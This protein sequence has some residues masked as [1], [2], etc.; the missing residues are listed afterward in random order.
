MQSS[1]IL[2]LYSPLRSPRCVPF[3]PVDPKQSFPA[4]ERGILAYWKKED[5]FRRSIRARRGR[6]VFRFYDGPPFATGLPHY[7]H[8]LAGTIKDVIPRYQTMRGK[9]VERR[10]GWDC[11]GL[12]IEYEIEKEHGIKGK[13]DIET[14]GIAKF[15]AL[16]RSAV[17][18]YT[19]EWRTTVER[20]GRWVDM[21]WDYR[22]MDPDYMESIWW[23]FKELWEKKL[24]EE[25]HKPMHVCP[26]CV[27]P[28]SNFEVT[29]GYKEVT[30][31]GV[32]VKFLSLQ[33]E[34]VYLLAWTTTPWTLPGN[35]F[36]A[37]KPRAQYVRV[38][39]EW[40]DYIVAKKCV[41]RIFTGRDY[42]IIGKPFTSQ[43]LVGKRYEPVFP[44]F[45]GE[46]R[47]FRIVAADFVTTD[48]GTGIV[49]IA[50]GFGEDDYKVWERAFRTSTTLSVTPPLLQHVT[51]DGRFT[52]AVTDFAGWEVKPK[53]DPLKT[54]GKIVEYLEKKGRVF[55]KET[56][57][58]SYPHCWRCDTPLLNYATSSWFVNVGKIKED[59]LTANKETE[60][61]PAHLR[62]GRF[63]K[64]LDGA[65][66][67]AISRQRYWG[68][69]LPIWRCS[70]D[71]VVIGSRDDLMKYCPERF[72]KVTVL[73]HG[74]SEGNLREIYQGEVPGTS[75]TAEGKRQAAAAALAFHAEEIAAIY[76]SPLARTRET[77]AIIGQIAGVSVT[78]DERLRESAFGTYEG[79][80][81]GLDERSFLRTA[82]RNPA[83]DPKN[84]A[85]I[86]Q[87]AG[88][89]MWAQVQV[90]IASFFADILPR[91]RGAHIIL[92]SHV[93]PIQ[94]II[95]FFT[96]EDPIKISRQPYPLYAST[97]TF[98]WD[99][100]TKAEL[101]LHRETVDTITWK[102]R[103][104]R[105]FR[106]IPDV[107]DC[108]FESGA[109]PYA[110][111]EGFPA[112]FIA[113]GIDQTRGWF[114]TLMVLSTALF[115]RPA[116]RHCIVNGIVLAADGKKMSKRLKNYPDP[117]ALAERHGAD[118]IRFAMMQSPAVR[119][120]DLRFSEK[121]V[122][123]TV[124]AVILPLWNAYGFFVT[125][126]NLAHF[127]P[128]SASAHSSHPLDQWIRAEIQDITNRMT[129]E[130]DRYNLSATCN[131]LH[132][133]IDALTNWYIRLSRRRFA[134]HC[135]RDCRG[136][137]GGRE[138]VDHEEQ[139]AALATLHDVLLTIVRLLAPFCPFIAETIYR[140]LVPEEYNSVHLTDWPNPRALSSEEHALL[141]K[142]RT[143]RR[144]VSLG[145][146]ARSEAG[147][148]L[149]Q[150]LTSAHIAIPPALLPL[151]TLSR[152]DI[153]L[154]EQELNVES[155]SLL[156][157]PGMLGERIA[158]VDA[159]RAG[160][161]L[162]ARV[163][164][165]IA[166]G[167]RGEFEER[168]DGS[169]RILDELLTPEE[170]HIVY[171][172]RDGEQVQG[173]GGVVVR[174]NTHMTDALRQKGLAR[175]LIRAIQRLRKEAGLKISDHIV[176][177]IEGIDGVVREYGDLI[178]KETHAI[179]GKVSNGTSHAVDLAGQKITIRF[180]YAQ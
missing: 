176:L 85:H 95:H 19:N 127:D 57:R 59:L 130:L 89:E 69:P 22:T 146:R 139:S 86:A 55:S 42:E 90:R 105:T 142:T 152:E 31:L 33:R 122:E 107:L 170:V 163:Q 5:I 67:W 136:G 148:K 13:K 175:D 63:G 65:R 46:T 35:Q 157:D 56:V 173:E 54:D 20:M 110:V 51:M 111:K 133:T 118:A 41:E 147:I 45:E 167:K 17:Q 135:S 144:I 32:V 84:P 26:R 80:S 165:V 109:M 141:Q 61:V 97:R 132:A 14:M 180:S 94:N 62:D 151:E 87:A 159:R 24:I 153:L 103:D 12:P 112:D 9:H 37:V 101:D 64:W 123:E 120:E 166:A 2:P 43:E 10:F 119:A 177:N 53:D 134:G 23:V 137:Q 129:E 75:L 121:L 88:V 60:W 30:D 70:D 49:H 72:T 92:V 68:T 79:K 58:H 149:R 164:D 11:H 27:T 115:K 78:V 6:T 140:N 15:N 96:R 16:C 28:L 91:H 150:P 39:C 171:Q 114:Y 162:G 113:E 36:L 106:R 108:W 83:L 77:A 145:L 155:I 93:D 47:S 99:H 4:L 125:Y 25:G 7:G 74:E 71:I 161:R 8:L 102:D 172:G 104:G 21:D 48:E 82:R 18:R 100:E 29:Q 154:L 116:F 179:F 50:P 160:P 34:R 52:N 128:P 156:A 169:F 76:A 3:D 117:T 138:E 174:V 126:A 131:E 158:F 44:Y 73:R 178:A 40:Y 98:F 66:D 168:D 124:R 1:A 81:I 38:Q 143:F